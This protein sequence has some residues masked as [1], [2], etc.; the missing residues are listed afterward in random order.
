LLQQD[1]GVAFVQATGRQ[2]QNFLHG[3]IDHLRG[4]CVQETS[5]GGIRKNAAERALR[6]NNW[7][8]YPAETDDPV[9]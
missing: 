3:L 4:V 1:L 8:F 6:L 7:T 2:G 5:C 9:D